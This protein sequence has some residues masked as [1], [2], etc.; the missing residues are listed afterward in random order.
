MENQDM[1]LEKVLNVEYCSH[2]EFNRSAFD[3]KHKFSIE[4]LAAL[5]E[6]FESLMQL[7]NFALTNDGKSGLY[8]V[9]TKGKTMFQ[10]KSTG[11]FIGT[12]PTK[13]GGVGGGVSEMIKIPID[14]TTLLMSI[15]IMAIEKKLDAIQETQRTILAFLEEKETA[16]FKGN[17]NVLAD[18][19][20]NYKFNF[21]NDKYKSHKHIL[22]QDIKR[23]A[24]QGIIFYNQRLTEEY[25]KKFSFH[26]D[27][28]VK[29]TLKKI[30]DCLNDYQ[31][32]LYSFSF[33]SFLEALLLENFDGQYLKS[34][35][36]KIREYSDIYTVLYEKCID[37]IEKDSEGS[38]EGL[39]LN[40]LSKISDGV[41]NLAKKVTA[42][43]TAQIADKFFN[44]GETL[45]EADTNRT[46]K[47][48]R[49]LA[50]NKTDNISPFIENINVL[51]DLY[52][53]PMQLMF[54][55]E[56]IYIAEVE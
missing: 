19:L 29:S 10:S 1:L 16:K 43:N 51:N 45:R 34:I 13:T 44:V 27:R 28:Q 3:E 48:I 20:D 37:K 14:P 11:N 56:Y 46:Q 17:L 24:E 54:N 5:G 8:Y 42:I 40:G 47:A 18:I 49:I 12:L 55:S 50:N 6:K 22:V 15:S 9:N 23:E 41:G 25:N 38:I 36:D 53:K 21:D 31:L 35:A 26:S 2:S 39:A 30:V 52:N 32:A 7:A 4:K 33:S